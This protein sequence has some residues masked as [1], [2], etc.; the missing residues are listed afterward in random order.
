V[1]KVDVVAQ[2]LK[3]H[4]VKRAFILYGASGE[5]LALRIAASIEPAPELLPLSSRSISSEDFKRATDL[6]QKA[7]CDGFVAIGGGTP[8]GLA[9]AIAANT[10]LPWIGI[11]TTYSGS[12]MATNWTYGKGA[13][14]RQGSGSAALPATAIYDPALTLSLPPVLSAQSGMNAMAHAVETLYGE[15]RS[16]VVEAMATAA[17]GHL[18]RSLP[19]VVAEPSNVEARTEAFYGAWLAAAFRAPVGVEHA[20]AQKVRQRFNLSHAGTHAVVTPYA[21][22]FNRG[23]AP[24]A[25]KT[26]ESAM[27]TDDAGLG[28]FDF[29]VRLGV[30]TGLRHLGMK[31]E[32]IPAAVEL[33]GASPIANPRPVSKADLLELI[34][35]AFHGE[36]P[37]F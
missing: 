15:G 6:I 10:R 23:A 21:I 27:K 17:I 8:I 36:A 30:P 2:E 19:R 32:D 29:N 12:E 26:I 9:K 24:A 16:P 4:G 11:T 1:G 14:A 13:E 20:I 28:L 35:Q 25:M 7:S 3:L 33:V 31:A 37:R 22:A 34:T 5:T 18:S